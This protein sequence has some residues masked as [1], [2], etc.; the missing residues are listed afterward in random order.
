MLL[1][2]IQQLLRSENLE[3]T[4]K[5]LSDYQ[6]DVLEHIFA[7]VMQLKMIWLADTGTLTEMLI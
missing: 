4:L 6:N 5:Q 3:P 1:K 7:N 2:G